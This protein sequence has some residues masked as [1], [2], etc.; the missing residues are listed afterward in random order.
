MS[1]AWAVGVD[2]SANRR[3]RVAGLA[4]P[5]DASQRTAI[6]DPSTSGKNR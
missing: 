4:W 3:F 2:F 6:E 5:G 1:A